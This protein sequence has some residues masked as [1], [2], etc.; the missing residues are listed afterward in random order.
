MLV[1]AKIKKL[2]IG[3]YLFRISMKWIRMSWKR[4]INIVS[5]LWFWNLNQ[6]S[7]CSFHLA[8]PYFYTRSRLQLNFAIPLVLTLNWFYGDHMFRGLYVAAIKC[9]TFIKHVHIYWVRLWWKLS[10][11]NVWRLSWPVL[12]PANVCLNYKFGLLLLWCKKYEP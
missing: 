9:R 8:S 12:I 6:C 10:V 5:L 1:R 4:K 3:S 2:P 11:T 7:S